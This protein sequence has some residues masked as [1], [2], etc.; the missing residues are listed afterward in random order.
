MHIIVEFR[1]LDLIL[2]PSQFS[3]LHHTVS[4][5]IRILKNLTMNS[6]QYYEYVFFAENHT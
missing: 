2:G 1:R 4:L 5:G 3:K 6:N